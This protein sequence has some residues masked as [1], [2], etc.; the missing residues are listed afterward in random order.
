MLRV[1]HGVLRNHKNPITLL[2]KLGHT[3]LGITLLEFVDDLLEDDDLL[4]E[5][6]KNDEIRAILEMC[7]NS[8]IN[9]LGNFYYSNCYI[10]KICS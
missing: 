4:V 1:T 7:S 5:W 9:E 3:Q 6:N 2:S 8:P 10:S